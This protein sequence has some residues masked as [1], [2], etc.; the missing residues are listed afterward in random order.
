MV[1][2]VGS[3]DIVPPTL[4]SKCILGERYLF[5]LIYKFYLSHPCIFFFLFLK[6][7]NIFLYYSILLRTSNG[8]VGLPHV[9]QGSGCQLNG[10]N[11]YVEVTM[12]CPRSGSDK[13]S[14]INSNS[15]RNLHKHNVSESPSVGGG[16]PK[17]SPDNMSAYEKTFI[18]PAEAV[19]VPVLQTSFS[20]SSLRRYRCILC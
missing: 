14:H 6:V 2:V 8:C 12:G 9:S 10:Q 1:C 16:D 5:F 7:P 18:Y 17:G 15:L 4:S 20:R 13:A 19:L 11:C 3:L